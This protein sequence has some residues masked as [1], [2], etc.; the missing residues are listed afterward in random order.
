[1]KALYLALAAIPTLFAAL[2]PL[3]QSTREIQS[4]LADARMQERL[5]SAEQIRDILKVEAG[6]LVWT[7]N[8]VMRVDVNYLPS[9][10]RGPTPF[11]LEFSNPIDIRAAEEANS[12][13]DDRL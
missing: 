12:D 8:Y 13:V 1:M 6:Y 5:G 2:P 10:L 4:I 9:E 7:Q 3:A 11:E